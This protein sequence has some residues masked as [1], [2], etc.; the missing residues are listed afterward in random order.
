MGIVSAFSNQ[1]DFSGISQAAQSEGLKISTAVHKAY[2]DVNEERTE[3]AGASGMVA[4]PLAM[5]QRPLQTFRADHPFVIMIRDRE[6]KELLFMGR[7]AN[8]G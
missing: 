3:A 8:P 5:V 4:R 1:A 2:L 6:S 7:V